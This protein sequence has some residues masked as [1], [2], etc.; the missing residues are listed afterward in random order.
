M[1]LLPGGKMQRCRLVQYLMHC[2]S[3]TAG[4]GGEP[5]AAAPENGIG[6][7]MAAEGMDKNAVA[8]TKQ[9]TDNRIDLRRIVASHCRA[10]AGSQHGQQ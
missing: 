6:G 10:E 1:G 2:A 4:P 8:V 3:C 5:N 9:I 7:T